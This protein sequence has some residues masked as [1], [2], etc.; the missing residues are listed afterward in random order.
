[1]S[2]K[3]ILVMV[4]LSVESRLLLEK[5]V[6]LARNLDAKLSLFYDGELYHEEYTSTVFDP[7]YHAMFYKVSEDDTPQEHLK[8]LLDNVG[9]P[10]QDTFVG[11]GNL[12]EEIERAIKE[13]NVD[14]VVCGH[15]HSFWHQ[16]TSSAKQLLKSTS[17]D[18]L[19]VPLK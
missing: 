2:Y 19:I 9:Y 8:E 5:T 18:L 10:I 17:I 7:R 6:S 15:H 16:F 12:I 1:M 4:D 3:H 11:S 14:L 13:L